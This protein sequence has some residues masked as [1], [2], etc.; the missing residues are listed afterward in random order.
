MTSLL[1]LL[2]VALVLSLG[3]SLA[4]AGQL[5]QLKELRLK[6]ENLLVVSFTAA[7]VA[8]ALGASGRW[9]SMPLGVIALVLSTANARRPGMLLVSVG[10]GLNL[11]ATGLFDGFMPVARSALSAIGVRDSV[12]GDATHIVTSDTWLIFLGDCLPTDAPILGRGVVSPGDLLLLIGLLVLL[13]SATLER[14]QKET[15]AM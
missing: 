15:A 9:L 7:L 12:A 3:L 10:V 5:G 8:P 1:T 11:L 2:A 13:V 4:S 6:H 14:E